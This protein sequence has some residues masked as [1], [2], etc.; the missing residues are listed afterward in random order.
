MAANPIQD[1]Y[2]FLQERGI[3]GFKNEYVVIDSEFRSLAAA[4]LRHPTGLNVYWTTLAGLGASEPLKKAILH[5][6]EETGTLT[7]H[8]NGLEFTWHINEVSGICLYV[9]Q[10]KK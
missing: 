2:K 9:L 1:A 6:V 5:S 3:D 4:S 10:E 7:W 8:E